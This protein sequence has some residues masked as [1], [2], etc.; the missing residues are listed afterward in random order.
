MQIS[1]FLLKS[2]IIFEMSP[3]IHKLNIGY[4]MRD[5]KLHFIIGEDDISQV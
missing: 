3:L 4:Y 1:Q 5:L 2:S